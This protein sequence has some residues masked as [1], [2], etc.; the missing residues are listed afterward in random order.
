ME[1]LELNYN[2]TSGT[3]GKGDRQT[4][5]AFLPWLVCWHLHVAEGK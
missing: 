4:R 1:F 2:S 5:G 3:V